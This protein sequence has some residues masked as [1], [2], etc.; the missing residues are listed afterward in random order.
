MEFELLAIEQIP[1]LRNEPHASPNYSSSVVS[2]W[3]L[4]SL[5][6]PES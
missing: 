1:P 2:S 5:V 6:T 3:T 4:V